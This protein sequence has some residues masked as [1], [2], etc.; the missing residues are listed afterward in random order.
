MSAGDQTS[1][2]CT[3]YQYVHLSRGHSAGVTQSTQLMGEVVMLVGKVKVIIYNLVA[4]ENPVPVHPE[5]LKYYRLYPN[6][7]TFIR[8]EPIDEN[9]MISRKDKK[10]IEKR[11]KITI[12]NIRKLLDLPYFHWD[13]REAEYYRRR[14]FNVKF[15]QNECSPYPCYVFQS[16]LSK[17]FNA[18]KYI[19][20]LVDISSLV[21]TATDKIK[22]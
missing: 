18:E 5:D 21:P 15:L 13:F 2:T 11:N 16:P 6:N 4:L 12:R 17:A 10:A 8:I 9:P 14:Q 3:N 19:S 1:R 22:I 7:P 20:A